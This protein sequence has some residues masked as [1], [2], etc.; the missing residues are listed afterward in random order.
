MPVP[1]PAVTPIVVHGDLDDALLAMYLAAPEIAVDTETMG[2]NLLRDRLCVVQICD[3][4][5]RATLVQI[6]RDTS[7]RDPALRAPRLKQL[8]EAP[9]VVKV[10]HFARFDVA[11]LFHNLGI[12]VNPLYC[13][14]TASRIIRTYTDRHALKDLALE[15]LDVE[16]DKRAQHTD[17]SR[18]SLKPEQIRYAASDVTLLLALKDELDVMLERERRRD[19]AVACFDVIPLLA[20][21][22]LRGFP[23][24]LNS[25]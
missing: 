16:M 15:L 10:F 22:D 20:Q 18:P 14:R 23:D 3:R 19:T 9:A 13:T 8:L 25:F 17:W 4:A 5:G 21:L 24:V 12:L 6:P 11:A 1:P 7:G 2:L